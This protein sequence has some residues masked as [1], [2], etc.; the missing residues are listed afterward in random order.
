MARPQYDVIV[1]GGGPA[2]SLA[3]YYL[4]KAGLRTT[5]FDA[6]EFPRDKPCGGGLEARAVREIPFDITRVLRGTMR[7]ARFT[8][9]LT[10]PCTRSYAQPLVYGVLRSEFDSFLLEHA[11][12]AGA[13]VRLGIR[14][15]GLDAQNRSPA[16]VRTDHG[17]F[18]AYA[19]VGADGANSVVRHILNRRQDY[20]WQVA[21]SCEV[22]EDFLNPSALPGE[23]I[24]VDWGSLPSGYGWVFPKKGC[25]NVGAGGPLRTAKLL[26]PYV[27]RFV[28]STQLLRP[29]ACAQLKFTGHQLPTLTRRTRLAS[30]RVLLVGDAGGLVEPFTGDGI[31]LACRSARLAADCITSALGGAKPD[32]S[33]YDRRVKS[34]IGPELLVSRKLVALSAA[35]PRVIYGL[36]KQNDKIWET[37]CRI[38]RGQ[39]S[40]QRLRREIL[41]PLEFAWRAV[42]L[43]TQCLERK[44]LGP[45]VVPELLR[46]FSV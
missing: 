4:A 22:P 21:I 3:G 11:A 7:R 13:A 12:Q 29:G 1:V 39:E 33:A 32:L 40:F 15:W 37:F 38:L 42:D 9:G 43:L 5:I 35:F 41:G 14:V 24:R 17:D 46:Q 19:L 6:K 10:E 44:A 26:R 25:V 20:F 45:Q 28:H 23:C 36:L 2:G 31:S 34:E 27:A 18:T 16:V 8:F 30:D